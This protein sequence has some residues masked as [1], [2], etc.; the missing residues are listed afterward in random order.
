MKVLVYFSPETL[1]NSYILI[2]SKESGA[3]LVDPMVFDV[4]LFNLIQSSKLTIEGILLT[5]A[6]RNCQKAIRTIQRIYTPRIFGPAQQIGDIDVDFINKDQEFYQTG[7][8]IK[9]IRP[10]GLEPESIMYHIDNYLFSGKSLSAGTIAS[11]DASY[12]RALLILGM[13]QL[14]HQLPASTIILPFSGPPSTIA[15]ER[16]CNI[17]LLANE[18]PEHHSL[19]RL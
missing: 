5:E 3:I 6:D 17:D 14:C 7:L 12:G 13:R 15:M 2:P 18:N 16:L 10:D 19:T 4:P 1:S 9:T 8:Q 11:V